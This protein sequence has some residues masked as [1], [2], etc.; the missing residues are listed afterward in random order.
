LQY[1]NTPGALC[2]CLSSSTDRFVTIVT[3]GT[4]FLKKDYFCYHFVG[5]VAM[6]PQADVDRRAVS[7]EFDCVTLYITR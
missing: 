5:D 3:E 7:V 2:L 4:N 1:K 6:K